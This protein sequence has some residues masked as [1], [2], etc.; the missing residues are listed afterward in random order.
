MPVLAAR[1]IIVAGIAVMAV[2]YAL[3]PATGS[4]YPPCPF[5]ALT[6]FACPGCGATR[7]LHQLLHGNLVTALRLNPL[8]AVYA[9][10]LAYAAL[11]T[12][13]TAAGRKPLPGPVIRPAL[14]W[15]LLTVIVTFGIVRNTALY[16][17]TG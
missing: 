12:V 2:V 8:L 16:P 14:I 1:T 15:I 10:I 11:S 5:R 9:P 3:D 13:L 17:F 4:F 7:A 6:G